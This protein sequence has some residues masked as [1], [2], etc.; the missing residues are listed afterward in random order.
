MPRPSYRES[1]AA[2]EGK[3][4]LAA[5]SLVMPSGAVGLKEGCWLRAGGEPVVA[6]A[7]PRAEV[8]VARE[9]ERVGAYRDVRTLILE[10][11]TQLAARRGVQELLT[12]V[13]G[14]ALFHLD[15]R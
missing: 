2:G 5:L 8:P 9:I 6:A 1:R 14:L 13:E 7:V 4:S 15:V 12:P 3:T 10:T 11:L